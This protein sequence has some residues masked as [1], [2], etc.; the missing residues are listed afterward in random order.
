MPRP[1]TQSRI[2]I[3]LPADLAEIEREK[4]VDLE[5]IGISFAD[6]ARVGQENKLTRRV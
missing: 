3:S 5:V 4:G 6:E 1:L 2:L